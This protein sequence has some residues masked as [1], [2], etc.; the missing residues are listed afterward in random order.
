MPAPSPSRPDPESAPGPGV[1]V[2]T[3]PVSSALLRLV[4]THRMAGDKLFGRIGLTP[5]QDL[6]LLHLE[7][8]GGAPQSDIVAFLQRDRSTVSTTLAAM[9]RAGLVVRAPSATDRRALHVSLTAAGRDLCP[10][11]KEVWA[12]LDSAASAGLSPHDRDRLIDAMDTARRSLVAAFMEH[13]GET[14]HMRGR[15][16]RTGPAAAAEPFPRA[17]RD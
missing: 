16:R 9:E 14:G 10:A 6:I 17:L 11:A 8:R 4:R 3:A 1:Q 2:P 13:P 12:E 15:G 7:E 5:P